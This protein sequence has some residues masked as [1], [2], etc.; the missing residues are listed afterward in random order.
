MGR[1]SAFPGLAALALLGAVSAL[2]LG[3]QDGPVMR[4]AY[5]DY[6]VE[7]VADGLEN[8]WGMAFLPGGDLLITE[9]PGR[10]RIVRDGQLLA[11]PV[12]GVPE[13]LAEGQGGLLD[14]VTHPDFA[15]NRMLYLSYSKPVGDGATTAVIRGRFEGDRLS[16]VEE[17][18][19]A[20]SR[21]NGHYGSRIVFDDAGY[22]FVTIGDRQAPPRGNL[23]AH[24][25][26][27]LS[28]HHGVVV[29]LHDDG[30]VPED[31]PFVGQEGALP[32]IWSYGHRNPQGMAIHPGTGALWATEHGPQ[33]G[34][35]LN[36]IQSG[37]NYGWPVVGYG[38][39]YRSGTAIH[40][41]TQAEGMES[42][43]HVWVPSIGTSG[44]AFYTG[45]RFPEWRGNAFAGGLSGAQIA[46]L[47]FDGD[48]VV[49]E[50]T[51]LL[52]VGRVRDVR[53]GP[54]GLLY[55]ALDGRGGATTAVVRMV[56][57]GN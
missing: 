50:E 39:N 21:G 31:N 47:T 1:P 9:R 8:P 54:D 7:T 36:L 33:G 53:Q 26:Q 24:P 44:L 10:L 23:A 12:A 16:Q 5:H 32:E 38:V 52:G 13:V 15:T 40:E 42:P 37:L 28:N 41:A 3:A 56:P 2:P 43:L 17:L 14:V 27:D 11:D 19:E 45:D 49:A 57:T 18:F 35:E 22:M 20:R 55:V 4:S 25:A 30:R 46:R 48:Q 51:L 29:R 34:D 6:R